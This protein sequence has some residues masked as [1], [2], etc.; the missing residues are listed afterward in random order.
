MARRITET[1]PWD[2]AAQLA[3]DADAAAYLDAVLEAGDPAL[4][5]AALGDVARAEGMT[6]VARRAGLARENLYKSLTEEGNPA[7]GTVMKVMNALGLRMRVVA[8][9]ETDGEDADDRRAF[10]ARVDEPER[11]AEDA[12]AAHGRGGRP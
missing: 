9:A 5:V 6:H 12:V 7:F 10:R 11:P 3:T 4:L 1:R 2:A 8:V